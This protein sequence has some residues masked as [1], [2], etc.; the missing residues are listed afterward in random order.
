ME[1]KW[2]SNGGQTSFPWTKNNEDKWGVV[3]GVFQGARLKSGLKNNV[4]HTGGQLGRKSGGQS[5]LHFYNLDIRRNIVK[6]GVI[7]MV[8]KGAWLDSG[9]KKDVY[10]TGGQLGRKSGGQSDLHFYNLD[11]RRNVVRWGVILM[12]PKCAWLDSALKKDVHHTGGHLG[13]RGGGQCDLHFYNL[14]VR[15]NV[16]K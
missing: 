6:W 13:R 4:H 15:R 12:V 11:V 8:P 10:H 3:F 5:D 2:R 1:V 9:L 7:L 16:V 14:D